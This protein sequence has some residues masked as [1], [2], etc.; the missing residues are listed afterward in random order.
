M[1]FLG[2]RNQVLS[3]WKP[4]ATQQALEREDQ[5]WSP[6]KPHSVEF[7]LFRLFGSSLAT[8]TGRLLFPW[9]DLELTQCEQPSPWGYLPKTTRSNCSTSTAA[10]KGSTSWNK[11]KADQKTC[12]DIKGIIHVQLW[13]HALWK[14]WEV[15]TSDWSWGSVWAGSEDKDRV[16]NCPSEC[17]RHKKLVN[18]INHY[19]DANGNHKEI[20]LHTDWDGYNQKAKM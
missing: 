8:V 19:S 5:I 16:V 9:L 2:L 6:Q 13:E 11:Q 17:W 3:H 4:K 15:L 10:C 14:T 18:R 20:P 1:P 7:S 12:W